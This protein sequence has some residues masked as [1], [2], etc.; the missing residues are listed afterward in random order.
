MKTAAV[1]GIVVLLAAG[2]A[3]VGANKI[4]HHDNPESRLVSIIRVGNDGGVRVVSV[5]RSKPSNLINQTT[6]NANILSFK[7]GSP[8]ADIVRQLQ[9]IQA[10]TL[11]DSPDRLLAGLTLTGMPTTWKSRQVELIFLDGKLSHVNH[12]IKT[13]DEND[14]LGLQSQLS[15]GATSP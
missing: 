14:P 13:K 10:V 7:I 3:L 2:T 6:G 5:D 11:E 4:R 9:Q 8:R 12:I 1:A 15:P